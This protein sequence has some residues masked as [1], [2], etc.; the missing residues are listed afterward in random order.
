MQ[1]ISIKDEVSKLILDNVC[2]SPT[3]LTKILKTNGFTYVVVRRGGMVKYIVRGIKNRKQR[4]EI[5][6]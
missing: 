2:E 1:F 3:R 4:F 5:K 6:L